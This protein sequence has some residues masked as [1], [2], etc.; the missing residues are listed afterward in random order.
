PEIASEIAIKEL[1]RPCYSLCKVYDL[2]DSLLALNEDAGNLQVMMLLRKADS[3]TLMGAFE[4]LAKRSMFFPRLEHFSDQIVTAIKERKEASS[5]QFQPVS[6]GEQLKFL[7]QL[8]LFNST[9]V[10]SEI[11]RLLLAEIDTSRERPV[12]MD[13]VLVAYVQRLI[14]RPDY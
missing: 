10:D 14:R 1:N 12:D 5:Q 6:A 2:F 13:C 7:D 11:F 8:G 4:H 3:L 9:E